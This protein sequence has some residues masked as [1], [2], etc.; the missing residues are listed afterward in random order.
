MKVELEN[1]QGQFKKLSLEIPADVVAKHVDDFYHRLGRDVTMNGFRKG[2]APLEVVKQAYKGRVDGDI[3]RQIVESTLFEAIKNHD[4]IPADMPSIDVQSFEET[5]PMKYSATFE[6]V[7]APALKNYKGF[8]EQME[9]V[10]VSDEDVEKAILNI[11]EQSANLVPALIGATYE[12]GSVGK[13][14]YEAKENGVVF[15][16]ASEKDVMLELGMGQVV[17]DFEKNVAGMK[18][19]DVRNF[20]ISF[21]AAATEAE[22]TPVSGK[23]LDF[24]VT[25][26][27]L[28]KKALPEATDEWASKLGPF[29]SLLD[30]K[31]RIREDLKKQKEQGLR[32]DLQDKAAAWL[33]ENN[34]VEVPQ[35]LHAKQLEQI[36]MDAGIQLSQMGLDEKGI[37]EKLQSWG[38]D[39]NNLATRQVKTSMLLSAIAKAENI[40]ASEEDVRNEIIRMAMQSRKKP[41]EVA[42]ELREKGM[43]AGLVRQLTELKALDWVVDQANRA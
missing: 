15:A 11:R 34:P 6:H 8:K 24:T 26:K 38:D 1:L 4:L 28:F 29:K 33:L 9:D 25:L 16:P 31:M 21:P 35:T 41:D 17:E 12:K 14:D 3:I 40:Q 5:A 43:L 39:M 42:K 37:E 32:R 18:P 19:N 23:T 13:L 20:S 27:E 10:T 30:L 22:K 36:A 2:K 7:P